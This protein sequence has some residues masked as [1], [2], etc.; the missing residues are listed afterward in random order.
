MMS[1]CSTRKALLRKIGKK[2]RCV[3]CKPCTFLVIHLDSVNGLKPIKISGVL[4]VR[5]IL[6]LHFHLVLPEV[7]LSN[8]GSH[9]VCFEVSNCI[10]SMV[11]LASSCSFTMSLVLFV[12]HFFFFSP[13]CLIF[14]WPH[15]DVRSQHR[16]QNDH[17]KLTRSCQ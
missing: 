17:I 14:R 1:R 16:C 5:L 2:G 12:L 15:P 7:D 8:T 4:L 11:R 9:H 3:T 6:P 13:C 10:T